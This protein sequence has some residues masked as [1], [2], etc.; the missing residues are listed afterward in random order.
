[1][2]PLGGKESRTYG[3]DRETG[4]LLYEC[5]MSGC[6]NYTGL[7]STGDIVL[8]QRLTQTVRAVE[9]RT[10]LERYILYNAEFKRFC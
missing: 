10:G 2:I 8:V 6:D 9:P 4:R 5:V 1:M 3:V 7:E